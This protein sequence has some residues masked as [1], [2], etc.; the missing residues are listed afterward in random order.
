[1]M[2]YPTECSGSIDTEFF[3]A[4][5]AGLKPGRYAS[6]ALCK[7]YKESYKQTGMYPPSSQKI[8]LMLAASG[9]ATIRSGGVRQTIVPLAPNVPLVPRFLNT[10][11]DYPEHYNPSADF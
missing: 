5:F 10:V 2:I 1:M 4:W 7:A 9:C 8:K 11:L 6:S 3:D